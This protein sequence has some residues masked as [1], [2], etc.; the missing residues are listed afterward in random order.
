[1]PAGGVRKMSLSVLVDQ[2]I[3]WQPD[4]NSFQRVLIPPSP[5]KLKI[6]RDLVAGVTGFNADRGDQLVIETLP[7]ETTLQLEPPKSPSAPSGPGA[8]PQFPALWPIQW[9]RNTMIMYGGGAAAFI[10]IALVLLALRRRKPK[11][12]NMRGSGVSVP[13]ELPEGEEEE[14]L[15]QA[16]SGVPVEQQ[17]QSKLA[18]RDALQ[19]KMDAQVLNQLKLSPV[20]TKTAEVLAKHL[21]ER[22]KQD[23]EVSAQI[24]RTWIREEEPDA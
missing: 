15:A 18:E 3:T 2:D 8:K 6:I 17:L 24:L 10:L 1:M 9:N 12:K 19:H 13:A 5:E 20:I 16:T 7:F 22:I 14:A 21:R 4:K 23:P 11:N